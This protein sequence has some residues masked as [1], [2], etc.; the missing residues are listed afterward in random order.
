MG[1]TSRSGTQKLKRMPGLVESYDASK[2]TPTVVTPLGELFVPLEGLL[3]VEA[4]RER[5]TKEIAKVEVELQTVRKKLSNDSFVSASASKPRSG[6][7]GKPPR[8]A[9][10]R[11]RKLLCAAAL[12][13]TAAPDADRSGIPRPR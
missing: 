2:G 9:A 8:Q 5:L 13:S 11:F 7:A 3:D 4:E 1:Y 6:E 10:H 12:C